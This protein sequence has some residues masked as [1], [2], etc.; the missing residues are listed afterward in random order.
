LRGSEIDGLN[1]KGLRSE[2]GHVDWTGQESIQT[3]KEK[4]C[5]RWE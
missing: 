4:S 3:N 5:Q 1:S 2:K